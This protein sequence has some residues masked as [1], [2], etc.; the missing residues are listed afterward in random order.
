MKSAKWPFHYLKEKAEL[1]CSI[2]TK[3]GGRDWVLDEKCKEKVFGTHSSKNYFTYVLN[4]ST[5]STTF[6]LS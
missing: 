5:L 4:F 1:F 6:E 2:W 3:F